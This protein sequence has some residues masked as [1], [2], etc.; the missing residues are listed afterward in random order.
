MPI[1]DD[2]AN[3]LAALAI[4]LVAVANPEPDN[5]AIAATAV[6]KKRLAGFTVMSHVL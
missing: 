2:Q 1:T 6:H 4:Y 5:K 3:M